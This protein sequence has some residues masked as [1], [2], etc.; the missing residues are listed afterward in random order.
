M[1]CP[2]CNTENK[3]SAKFCKKCKYKF[4]DTH[5]TIK[6]WRP[7]WKWHLKTLA[8]IYAALIILFFVVNALMKP[9]MRQLPKEIT[10]W[11][12]EQE[13]EGSQK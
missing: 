7:D 8:I 2:K 10:P 12:Q 5:Q 13:K 4:E 11:L 3:D 1:K 6:L 9:Y